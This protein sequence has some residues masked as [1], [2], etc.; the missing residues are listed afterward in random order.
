M[1]KDKRIVLIK[2]ETNK[3]TFI[4]RNDGALNAKGE[5][6]FFIDPD[7]MILENSLQ[8]LY[9]ATLKYPDVDIIQFKAYKKIISSKNLVTWAR[10]YKKYD[11]IVT[12][13]ELC[14]IMFYED[15][16]LYLIM[17]YLWGKLIKRKVFVETIEKLGHYKNVHM[18]LHEDMAIL[19]ALLQIAKNY[20]YVKIYGYLYYKNTASVSEN[21]YK[22]RKA[23]KT[24]RDN[25]LFSEILFDFSK[26]TTFDK[27]MA[28]FALNR[29]YHIYYHVC[30]FVTDGFEY[31]FKVLNKFINCEVLANKSKFYV[32]R[33]KKLFEETQKKLKKK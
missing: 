8:K 32:F 28:L 15:N 10:G 20:V 6:I 31:I 1:K 9:E 4:T 13:P 14:S 21:K 33:L 12:Q 2:H 24:I 16:Y 11:K 23:N 7:D 26:N 18:T 25:F 19:F 17:F 22:Y 27:K 29:I 3:G 30:T 5:Y